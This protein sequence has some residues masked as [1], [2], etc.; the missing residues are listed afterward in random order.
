MNIFDTVTIK[1][2]NQFSQHSQIVD[3]MFSRLAGNELLKGGILAIIIWWAW[4]KTDEDHSHNRKHIILTLIS[5]VFAMA[6]ARG[7][8]LTLPFRLRPLQQ[9][10]L[11]FLPPY[12]VEVTDLEAW[13]SF[14]SD[15][16]V[17]F[18]ALSVGLLY[19]SKK[20]GIFSL[21]YTVLFISFPRIYLGLH[22]PT[23]IIAGAIIGTTIAIISNLCPLKSKW[24]QSIENWSYLKPH[25]FYPLF[26][27]FTYQIADNF[28]GSRA[29]ISSGWNLLQLILA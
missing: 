26:F 20:I 13:S 14:P 29:I 9:G 12:G 23:D 8:A 25:L 16:A 6:L 11:N 10:G 19:V 18:F 5:C 2:V 4:F 1:F 17:L 28:E 3:K 24:L 7:L 21:F 27:L 15:H 22:Y